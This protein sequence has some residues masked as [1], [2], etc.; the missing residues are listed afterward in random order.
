MKPPRKGG[1]CFS[2][3]LLPALAAPAPA[4]HWALA[5]PG[6]APG[7]PRALQGTLLSPAGAFKS[8]QGARQAPG[9]KQPGSRGTCPQPS[10]AMAEELDQG[11]GEHPTMG[12]TQG[13]PA[14]QAAPGNDPG[15]QQQLDSEP[16]LH[17]SQREAPSD[18]CDSLGIPSLLIP[19]LPAP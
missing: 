16:L 15:A 3:W 4:G 14:E 19:A 10:R 11:R 5:A 2:L 8:K 12:S 9:E 13:S 17:S 7:H 18:T 1:L 6:E